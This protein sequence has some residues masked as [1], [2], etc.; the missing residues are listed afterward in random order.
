VKL[1]RSWNTT[2]F[3]RVLLSF[4][5]Q[6]TCIQANSVNEAIAWFCIFPGLMEVNSDRIENV[7]FLVSKPVTAELWTPQVFETYRWLSSSQKLIYETTENGNGWNNTVIVH[8]DL[9]LGWYHARM[10]TE[11]RDCRKVQGWDRFRIM[12]SSEFLLVAL[13]LRILLRQCY[14]YCRLSVY[15]CPRADS[16]HFQSRGNRSAG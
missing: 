14:L 11:V 6:A 8:S 2:R 15:L 12:L 9:N 7:K 5:L 13:I 1:E 10:R 4:C 3:S 16:Y